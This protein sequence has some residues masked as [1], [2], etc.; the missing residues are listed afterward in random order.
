MILVALTIR[1]YKQFA[2]EHLFEPDRQGITAVIGP[3]GAGKTT[4]F[5]AIEWCL[6][7]PRS[8][9]NADV[10]PR[11]LGGMPMVRVTLEEP[12]TGQRHVIER[13]LSRSKVMQAEVWDEA[14]P[15]EMIA[16]G[17]APVKKFVSEQLI[18]LGHSAFISTFFTRQKEL[19]FFGSVGDTKRRRM[20][21]QMI[22]IEAVRLAQESIGEQRTKAANAAEAL[23]ALADQEGE[24]RDL[25]EEL[26][27]AETQL[28]EDSARVA[29]LTSESAIARQTLEAANVEAERIR[30][31]AEEDRAFATRLGELNASRGRLE[32]RI[33]G[34]ETDLTRLDQE[35]KRRE[36]L[37]PVATTQAARQTEVERWQAERQ[38]QTQIEE[39]QRSIQGLA[40]EQRQGLD[41]SRQIV[42]KSATALLPD[43]SWRDGA[44]P[45]GEIGRLLG[46][47]GGIDLAAD[48][49]RLAAFETY[50]SRKTD[51]ERA[52][53]QL[54]SYHER[55]EVRRHEE[56]ALLRTGDPA[57]A[58][59]R[60]RQSINDRRDRLTRHETEQRQAVERA[61]QLQP[62][63]SNLRE[64][65][66]DDHC[67]TCG[68]SISEEE[69][70]GVI[71]T[72]TEQIESWNGIARQRATDA[73]TVRNEIEQL[74]TELTAESLRAEELQHVRNKLEQGQQ[75]T[76]E[77]QDEVRRLA[78]SLAQ[79]TAT[80]P[81]P[82]EIER[83][84]ERIEALSSVSAAAQGLA[85]RLAQLQSLAE[86]ERAERAELAQLGEVAYEEIAHRTAV[87]ALDE[88]N[89]AVTVLQQ[90]DRDLQRRE[91]IEAQRAESQAALQRELTAIA[92]AQE[93][94]ERLAW[95]EAE[96]ANARQAV[97]SAIEAERQATARLHLAQTAQRDRQGALD[98]LREE[99]RRLQQ[100]RD[101]SAALRR[102]ADELGEMYKEFGTFDQY[103]AAR[104]APRMAE[105]TSE[106]L[107][108]ATDGKFTSVEFD[109]NYGIHV[110]DGI[111]EKF[112]LESFSG[113]ERDVVALCAR[114]ALSQLIGSS[115]AHPPSFLVLDEVFGAL[116]RDRRVQLLELLGRISESIE[117]FQQ[118][119]I[120]SHVDDVRSS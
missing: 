26:A 40:T 9:S 79:A 29:Q 31:R 45:L 17:S 106:L 75:L 2:G 85:Q 84:R 91:A 116:D 93:Q 98:R 77:K 4:L 68:R 78:D 37:A 6:Y 30:L 12:R 35:A 102:E 90:I 14:N 113:G 47:G 5:E 22:G 55:L 46:V 73:R 32:T 67:P 96:S 56:Q 69:A 119:F 61:G 107:E 34:L 3:N 118:M 27:T 112:P 8:I 51:L 39:R 65:T 48:R 50:T 53:A 7:G 114:L 11:G 88:A 59:D 62:L 52:E 44:E 82:G 41:A 87:A 15:G 111:A 20:V 120:I 16:T 43:W 95:N 10:L 71:R 33:E 89:K 54:H 60:I 18:G 38:R 109:E 86:R 64:R 36:T 92:E 104:I 42:A 13:R 49:K 21:G 28:A 99:H 101:R 25:S 23:G 74:T 100:Q 72:L 66:F 117:A 1:D 19:S 57:V 63:V 105:Q 81:Q 58:I 94:R 115:A 24:G 80:P 83:L 108:I 103:V 97:N 110:Y 70:A 76:L